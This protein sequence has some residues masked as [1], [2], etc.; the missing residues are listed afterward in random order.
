MKFEVIRVVTAS[1]AKPAT[2]RSHMI[3][4]ADVLRFP[5]GTVSA[6]GCDTNSHDLTGVWCTAGGF[7]ARHAGF[8]ATR[9]SG[10]PAL[11]MDM[12]KDDANNSH[13]S[14]H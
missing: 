3:F 6:S 4:T 2:Q 13:L 11:P 7:I 12:I 14:A 1:T 10:T 8:P 9:D 5:G